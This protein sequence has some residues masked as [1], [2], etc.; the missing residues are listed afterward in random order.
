MDATQ[1]TT[2]DVMN[3]IVLVLSFPIKCYPYCR[4]KKIQDF[5]E[6][7]F[8]RFSRFSVSAIW[9]V[10]VV[11]VFDVDP[12]LDRSFASGSLSFKKDGAL[13]GLYFTRYIR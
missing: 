11:L 10:L 7:Q 4:K 13:L 8:W 9:Q 6:W 12:Y 1:C 5:Q 2:D 3:A